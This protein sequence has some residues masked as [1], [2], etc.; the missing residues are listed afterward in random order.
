MSELSDRL[1]N[2]CVARDGQMRERGLVSVTTFVTTFV[3]TSERD[4]TASRNQII[5]KGSRSLYRIICKLNLYFPESII[6]HLPSAFSLCF[7]VFQ[8]QMQ[9]MAWHGKSYLYRYVCCGLDGLYQCKYNCQQYKNLKTTKYITE[10]DKMICQNLSQNCPNIS[11]LKWLYTI[12]DCP[13][14][15]H[16][17]PNLWEIRFQA[18]KTHRNLNHSK[19]KSNILKWMTKSI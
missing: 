2:V 12:K 18:E 5:S 1:L 8:I 10:S 7:R 13:S 11:S 3:T 19:V 9:S 15:L 17:S 6:K 14:S 16:C 4:V